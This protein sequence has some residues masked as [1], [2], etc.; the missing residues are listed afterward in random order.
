M[1]KVPED[2]LMDAGSLPE[3]FKTLAATLANGSGGIG[4]RGKG[5]QR[6]I[7]RRRNGKGG[8]GGTASQEIRNQETSSAGC[9]TS[10]IL[11]SLRMA[12]PFCSNT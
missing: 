4:L 5:G 3:L 1:P 9:A 2:D 8:G 6:Q 11:L 10:T 7:P 12:A